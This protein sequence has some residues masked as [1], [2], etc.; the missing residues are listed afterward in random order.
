MS[1]KREQ[2]STPQSSAGILSIAPNMDLKGLK[3]DPRGV[4]VF[5]AL[6]VI[7]VKV[8]SYVVKAQ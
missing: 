4:V 1:I 3:F 7:I 8:A 5:T 2:I 6:F